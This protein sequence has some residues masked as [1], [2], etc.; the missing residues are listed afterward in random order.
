MITTGQT[1]DEP[2]MVHE[3]RVALDKLVRDQ[4]ALGEDYLAVWKT[5]EKIAAARGSRQ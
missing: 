3:V 2:Q 5:I 4:M 1:P